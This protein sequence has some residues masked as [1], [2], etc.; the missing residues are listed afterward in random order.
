MQTIERTSCWHG[1]RE[2]L[3]KAKAAETVDARDFHIDKAG[4]YA[5]RLADGA[6][7]SPGEPSHAAFYL[8]C[9]LTDIGP[10]DPWRVPL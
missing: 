3:K 10:E 1:L 2:E 8:D 4:A 6:S 9:A 5:A 7:G